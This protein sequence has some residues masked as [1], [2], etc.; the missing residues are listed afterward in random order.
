MHSYVAFLRGI[1]IGGKTALPMGE[2]ISIF[3]SF[4]VE[5]VQTY[6]RS[7]NVVFQ[8]KNKLESCF[9]EKISKA[10]E[11]YKNFRPT[12]FI[13]SS[14]KL[15]KAIKANPFNDIN[16]KY[17]HFYFIKE[18]P[19]NNDFNQLHAVKSPTEDFRCIGS[20]FYLH[21]PD[22]FENSKIARKVE[23]IINLPMT[24]RNLNTVS[25][26]QELVNNYR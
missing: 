7:G 14:T 15:N 20:V 6:I 12:A 25:K 26:V 19:E 1:N 16:G 24:A 11:N 9:S 18:E 3:Q 22:G 5:N 13:L 2:L 8:S 17:I 23:K 4:D 10:I 21:T